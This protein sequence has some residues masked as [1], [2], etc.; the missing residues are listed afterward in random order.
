LTIVRGLPV[1]IQPIAAATT[2][3]RAGKA[4]ACSVTLGWFF[5]FGRAIA[6]AN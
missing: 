6:I 1:S 5:I 3:R 4:Y 2:P